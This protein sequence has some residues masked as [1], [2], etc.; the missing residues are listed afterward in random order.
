MV[1]GDGRREDTYA[2]DAGSNQTV[3][4]LFPGA[5]GDFMLAL[6]TLRRLRRLHASCRMV[7]AVGRG[8]RELA[9][10]AGAAD[11]V[12]AIDG[13]DVARLLGG[14][15]PPAWWG[16]ARHLHAWMGT[17]D[18]GVRGA[19]AR[20][21]AH[22]TF[23]AVVRGDGPRHAAAEYG[24]GVGWAA[25]WEALVAGAALAAAPAGEAGDAPG[26]D[27]L[28]VHRGAGAPGKRWAPAGFTRV[29]QAWRAGGGVV[30]DLRG[31]ADGDLPPLAGARIVRPT[32][33]EL[34]GVLA[35]AGAF[36]GND[37]GPAHVAGAVGAPGVVL[38]GPTRPERWRPLSDRL[39]AL[40]ADARARDD[41]GRLA[42]SVVAAL[43]AARA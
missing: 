24:C 27:V 11:V 33:A 9:V 37:S 13:P 40:Q 16:R 38:F 17:R 21:A 25:S 20:H 23:A 7:L 42:A 14:G 28:V 2:V 8:L 4:A 43:E 22:A 32:V 35:A 26:A 6:P 34:P 15:A 19:L 29:A 39:R 3:V 31:P 5:L 12:V 10:L 41:V 36:V 18:P 30:L 1:V